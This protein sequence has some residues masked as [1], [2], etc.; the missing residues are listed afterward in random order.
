MMLWNWLF[1]DFAEINEIRQVKRL[2][3]VVRVY[4]SN[5]IFHFSL[6]SDESAAGVAMAYQL[7]HNLVIFVHFIAVLTP[8]IRSQK[9]DKA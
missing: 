5:I 6:L 2:P 1:G 8:A 3:R 7:L 9:K 4:E